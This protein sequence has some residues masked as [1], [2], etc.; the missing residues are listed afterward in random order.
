MSVLIGHYGTRQG[1]IE[2]RSG[3]D[4]TTSAIGAGMIGKERGLALRIG[5]RRDF[6]I[7][8]VGIGRTVTEGIGDLGDPADTII[9]KG[10]RFQ[11]GIGQ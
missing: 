5:D 1:G 6:A 3:L 9:L 10:G 2:C 8:R 4:T 7:G 11:I